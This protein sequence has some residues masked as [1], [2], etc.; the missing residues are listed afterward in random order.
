[1][2]KWPSYLRYLGWYW[3]WYTPLWSLSFLLL[4]LGFSLRMEHRKRVPRTGPVLILANHQS[5]FDPIL[6]GLAATR[7]LVYLARKTLFK[8]PW[9]GWLITSLNSVPLDQDGV[10]KDGLKAILKRLQ[11]GD[12]VVVFPEG[13]RTETGGLSPLKP[14]VLLLIKRVRMTI[15]PMGIAGAF[16]ALP[17]WEKVP[18]LAP[19]LQEATPTTLAVTVGEPIDSRHYENMPREQALAELTQ[20]LQKVKDRA[21]ALRRKH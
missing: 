12:A 21:E 5:F 18:R 16:E 19:L 1:M 9:F 4:T 20:I 15:V 8:P 6:L 3:F 17:Y 13:T 10:A 2:P 14:G 11:C 7:P